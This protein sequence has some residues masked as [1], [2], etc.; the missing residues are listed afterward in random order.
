[1]TSQT[2]GGR[3]IHLSY[4]ELMESEAINY[5]ILQI[6]LLQVSDEN[7]LWKRTFFK[8]LSNSG[9]VLKRRFSVIVWT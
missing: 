7:G 5:L 1:M 8:T 9:N 4:G 3:S 2:P 6:G